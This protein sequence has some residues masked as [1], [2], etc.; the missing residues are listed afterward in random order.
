MV[1]PNQ[2]SLRLLFITSLCYC[3]LHSNLANSQQNAGLDPATSAEQVEQLVRRAALASLTSDQRELAL[4]QRELHRLE[5]SVLQQTG[6]TIGLSDNFAWLAVIATSQ[7]TGIDA[8][9]AKLVLAAKPD[10]LTHSQVKAALL[11]SL[12]TKLDRLRRQGRYNRIVS[13]LNALLRAGSGLVEGRVGPA[14]RSAVDLIFVLPRSFALTPIDRRRQQLA[15]EWLDH[16]D[17]PDALKVRLTKE[18]D[19]VAE[20]ILKADVKNYLRE[21]RHFRQ[22]GNLDR[23]RSTVQAA[24]SLDE[25]NKPAL[26]LQ[27]ALEKQLAAQQ[28]RRIISNLFVGQE[29]NQQPTSSALATERALLASMI[30]GD[31][32]SVAKVFYEQAPNQTS[33]PAALMMRATLADQRGRRD[34][35]LETLQQLAADYPQTTEGRKAA[36]TLADPAYNPWTDLAQKR[37]QTFR[38]AWRYA[39]WGERTTSERMHLAGRTLTTGRLSSLENLGALTL[40]EI[41]VRA[42]R[43]KFASPIPQQAAMAAVWRVLDH[44][45]LELSEKEEKKLLLELAR[46]AAKMGDEQEAMVYYELC[47]ELTPRR[48]HK[49]R[50]AQARRL[51]NQMLNA[52]SAMQQEALARRLVREYPLAKETKRA[53]RLLAKLQPRRELQLELPR[54]WLRED[55]AYWRELG[56]PLDPAWVDGGRLNG[57]LAKQAAVVRQSAPETV[58]FQFIRKNRTTSAPLTPEALRRLQL[59]AQSRHADQFAVENFQEAVYAQRL[60]FEIRG[61]IGGGGFEIYPWFGRI[62]EDR[63]RKR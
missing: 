13:P 26:K 62:A 5:E 2:P 42:I 38:A 60:P 49:L 31:Q 24:L 63:K 10:S 51:G 27:A 9:S 11:D 23:A 39:L 61:S 7:P 57:E 36:D 16:P 37:R 8:D 45:G 21:G 52:S 53:Q 33:T 35:A 48:F 43:L 28:S 22:L 14:L 3:T 46:R 54:Q 40:L 12:P 47:G 17:L 56:L 32:Q 1:L 4:V 30:A 15:T 58:E 25:Q 59:I 41:A 19:R 18:V 50:K 20:R 6:E 29:Q 34:Q 44:P 55:P